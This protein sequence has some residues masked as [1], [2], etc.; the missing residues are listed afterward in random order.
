MDSARNGATASYGV[1]WGG[2]LVALLHLAETSVGAWRAWGVARRTDELRNR[3]A[4]DTGPASVIP[5]GDGSRY[6]WSRT[7]LTGLAVA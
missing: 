5:F 7:A 1:V 3:A 4:G 2:F 6:S